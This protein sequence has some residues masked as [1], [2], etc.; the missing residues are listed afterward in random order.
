MSQYRLTL[1]NGTKRYIQ[2]KDYDRFGVDKLATAF[3]GATLHAEDPVSGDEYEWGVEDLKHSDFYGLRPR[4]YD[5]IDADAQKQ[6]TDDVNPTDDEIVDEP[7]S[8]TTGNGKGAAV[9]GEKAADDGAGAVT[10]Q[11]ANDPYGVMNEGM[12]GAESSAMK[13]GT[14]GGGANGETIGNFSGLDKSSGGNATNGETIGNGV[15]K[16]EEGYSAF[17]K[18]DDLRM[19]RYDVLKAPGDVVTLEDGTQKKKADVVKEI[20][21]HLANMEQYGEDYAVVDGKPMSK[22]NA[23]KKV[24][25]M[26]KS[27]SLGQWMAAKNAEIGAMKPENT[28]LSRVYGDKAKNGSFGMSGQ[29]S[30]RP[31][32]QNNSGLSFGEVNRAIKNRERQQEINVE[33][34]K[35]DRV[36]KEAYENVVK[37]MDFSKSENST[38]AMNAVAGRMRP[39]AVIADKEK[40]SEVSPQGYHDK[41][42]ESLKHDPSVAKLAYL[43]GRTVDDTLKDLDDYVMNYTLGKEAEK[44]KPNSVGDYY[45]KNLRNSFIGRIATMATEDLSTR[46]AKQMALGEYEQG[47]NGLAA[48]GSEML[49]MGVDMVT[50][51]PMFGKVGGWIGQKVFSKYAYTRLLQETGLASQAAMRTAMSTATKG[52]MIVSR[53]IGSGTTFATMDATNSLMSGIQLEGKADFGSALL[54]GMRGFGLGSIVGTLGYGT[55]LWSKGAGKLSKMGIGAVGIGAEAGV[56]TLPEYIEQ[57]MNEDSDGQMQGRKEGFLQMFLKNVAMVKFFKVFGEISRF[58]DGVKK[59]TESRSKIR[60]GFD[61]LMAD[62]PEMEFTADEIKA[63]NEQGYEGKDTREVMISIARSAE[64]ELMNMPKKIAE[65]SVMQ[66]IDWMTR[67]TKLGDMYL[68][69]LIPEVAKSKVNYFLTGQPMSAS[70]VIACSQVYKDEDGKYVVDLFT[71]GADANMGQLYHRMKFESEDEAQEYRMNNVGSF[72]AQKI[73]LLEGLIHAKFMADMDANV[74]K[75]AARQ[76]GVD[77][78]SLF[79]LWREGAMGKYREWREVQDGKREAGEGTWTDEQAAQFEYL[80]AVARQMRGGFLNAADLVNAR[81]AVARKN[82]LTSDELKAI[83]EKPFA[84]RDVEK[85]EQ[86]IVAEYIDELTRRMGTESHEAEATERAT[87][88]LKAGAEALPLTSGNGVEEAQQKTEGNLSG[89]DESSG[90][91]AD[92][93]TIGNGGEGNGG[94][95]VMPTVPEGNEYWQQDFQALG[96]DIRAMIDGANGILETGDLDT[97]LRLVDENA[98]PETIEKWIDMLADDKK[99]AAKGLVKGL[100]QMEAQRRGAEKNAKD[101]VAA[102][103]ANM[104]QFLNKQFARKVVTEATIGSGDSKELVYVIGFAG[105]DVFV[106]HADGRTEQLPK[107]K[108]SIVREY[109]LDEEYEQKTAE[110]VGRA[111]RMADFALEHHP[112]TVRPYEGAE[113]KTYDGVMKVVGVDEDGTVAMVHTVYDEKTRT[114]KPKNEQPILMDYEKTLKEQDDY[115]GKVRE[116]EELAK[117][118]AERK[119]AEEKARVEAE[120]KAEEERKAAEEA[121]RKQAEEQAKAEEEARKRAEEEEA[122][123]AAEEEQKRAEEENKQNTDKNGN[124]VDED[125][126]LVVEIAKSVDDIGD[127]D[128]ENPTRNVQLPELSSQVSNAIGTDGKPVVIKKNIFEKN[129]TNHPELNPNESRN[130]LFDALYRTNLYGQSQ[131]I[132]RPDYK[133]AIHTG[134]KNS[135]VVL[136]VYKGKDNV[137]IIGWRKIDGE[138]LEKLKRQAAREGGQFLILSPDEG[139][140]AALSALPSDLSGGKI[141]ENDGNKQEISPKNAEIK[142]TDEQKRS[143]AA[144]RAAQT[145]K[146]RGGESHSKEWREAVDE[147]KHSGY[148][149]LVEMIQD[150]EPKDILDVAAMIISDGDLMWNTEDVDGREIKGVA[151]MTGYKERDRRKFPYLFRTRKSGGI[152]VE[153]A[154]DRVTEMCRQLGIVYD[155]ADAMAGVNAIIEVIRGAQSVGDIKY[156]TEKR[157]VQRARDEFDD[158]EEEREMNGGEPMKPNYREDAGF[159]HNIEQALRFGDKEG[160]K[161]YKKMFEVLL[162]DYDYEQIDDLRNGVEGWKKSLRI[163]N[164]SSEKAQAIEWLIK[165][166]ENRIQRLE[167]KNERINKRKEAALKAQEERKRKKQEGAVGNGQL[168]DDALSSMSIQEL[169]DALRKTSD[170]GEKAKISVELYKARQMQGVEESDISDRF[171]Q[172]IADEA[173]MRKELLLLDSESDELGRKEDEYRELMTE[174][175]DFLSNVDD[176]ELLEAKKLPFVN[177]SRNVFGKAIRKEIERRANEEE[178]DRME[179][180][181]RQAEDDVN[182]NPTEAQKKA[183]NYKMGHISFKGF[184]FTIENTKGSIRSGKDADGNEWS[185]KMNNTYGYIRGTEGVDGDHIDVFLSDNPQ[186]GK[187]YVVD[188]V[189][190]DGSFDEHKVMFGFESEDEAR[191]AYLANYSEGWHGLGKITEV[192]IADFKKWIDS[193]H[194]KTKPFAEYAQSLLAEA[195]ESIAAAEGVGT[196]DAWKVHNEQVA[197][198]GGLLFNEQTK[199]LSQADVAA[200]DMFG[201]SIGRTIEFMTGDAFRERYGVDGKGSFDSKRNAIVINSDICNSEEALYWTMSHESTHAIKTEVS[202][203]VWDGFVDL[204]KQSMGADEFQKKYD[205]V[206]NAYEEAYKASNEAGK[207]YNMPGEADIEEEIC[208]NWAGDIN[209]VGDAERARDLIDKAIENDTDVTGIIQ[210]LIKYINSWLSRVKQLWKAAPDDINAEITA[211]SEAL[212]SARVTWKNMYMIA[213]KNNEARNGELR[214]EPAETKHALILPELKEKDKEIEDKLKRIDEAIQD[215]RRF[216]RELTDAQKESILEMENQRRELMEER[217]NLAWEEKEA[218]RMFGLTDKDFELPKGA[219]V[220]NYKDGKGRNTGFV[221][222]EFDFEGAEAEQKEQV[223]DALPKMAGNFPGREESSGSGTDGET[224]GNGGDETLPLTPGDFYQRDKSSGKKEKTPEDFKLRRLKSGEKCYVERRYVEDKAFTFNG[225]EKIESPEDIAYLFRSLED[226]AIENV[227]FVLIKNGKATILHAG[228]GDMTGSPADQMSPVVAIKNIKPDAIVFVHNHPGGSLN[229][230]GADK[231]IHNKLYAM[232]GDKLR[233]SIIIDQKSGKYSEFEDWG[234]IKEQQRPKDAGGES[235]DYKVY[236]FSK[237]VFS[238]DYVFGENK[239]T[240]SKDIAAFISSH[241]LGD[242]GKLGVLLA[243]GQ[244]Y[245]TANMFLKENDLTQENAAKIADEIVEMASHTSSRTAFI[246]GS[247]KWDNKAASK[248]ANIVKTKSGGAVSV[249]DALRLKGN[250]DDYYSMDDHG[251]LEE[252]A[253]YGNAVKFA[254][255]PELAKEDS[256]NLNQKAKEMFG[257]TNDWRETRWLLSDGT[258]L[259]FSEKKNGGEPGR[260]D[261]DHR[262]IGN[263]YDGKM[264]ERW[265]YLADFGSRG[266]IRLDAGNGYGTMELMRK[267]TKEQRE[268][269]NFFIRKSEGCLDIDFMNDNYDVDHSVSYEDATSSRILADIDR[270]YDD[271]LKPEGNVKFSL[272]EDEYKRVKD[273]SNEFNS[274]L[275]SYIQNRLRRHEYLNMHNYGSLS[276]YIPNANEIII[277]QSVLNKVSK[278]HDIDLRSIRNLPLLL[279]DPILTFRTTRGDS[280]SVV[281]LIEAKDR[282]GNNIVVAIDL[283]GNMDKLEVN[284]V[285]SLYGKDSYLGYKNW[286]DSIISGDVDKLKKWI[287]S[288]PEHDVR[289]VSKSTLEILVSKLNE[290]LSGGKDTEN[291]GTEQ[292]IAQKNAE[293]GVKFAL[294]PD[295]KPKKV[296]TVYKMMRKYPD[297]SYGWLFIDRNSRV[298]KGSWY[299]GD[300]PEIKPFEEKFAEHPNEKHFWLWSEDGSIEDAGTKMP[301]KDEVNKATEEGKRYMSTRPGAKD[302]GMLLYNVG[303]SGNDGTTVAEYAFRP[304]IHATDTPSAGHIGG[305]LQKGVAGTDVNTIRYRAK[306]EVWMECEV[307]DDVDYNDEALANASLIKSGANKGKKNRKEAQLM[308]MPED[309]SYYYRTNTNADAIQDWIIAGAIRPVRELSDA[310]VA[311]LNK[312][313]KKGE[314]GKD[315]QFSPDAVRLSDVEGLY[316]TD[317]ELHQNAKKLMEQERK[318]MKAAGWEETEADASG[319][320]AGKPDGKPSG[321]FADG[322]KVV[323]D[324]VKF[325][326]GDK[327][328]NERLKNKY[329]GVESRKLFVDLQH[330]NDKDYDK[331]TEIARRCLDERTVRLSR[332]GSELDGSFSTYPHIA[333][334]L[335]AEWPKVDVG[336]RGEDREGEGN[337]DQ[338]PRSAETSQSI[339]V[340]DADQNKQILNRRAESRVEV[341]AKENGCWFDYADIARGKRIGGGFECEV[342]ESTEKEGYVVKTEFVNSINEQDNLA[343][344]LDDIATFNNKAEVETVIG[345]TRDNNGIFCIVTEQPY[346]KGRTVYEYFAGDT[347]KSNA[348][349]DKY[350]ESL[351]LEEKVVDDEYIVWTDGKFTYFDTNHDNLIIDDNGDIHIID[352]KIRL[353]DGSDYSNGDPQA[354]EPFG[355]EDKPSVNVK[356]AI[357]EKNDPF[358]SNAAKAVEGIKQ[359]KATPEQWLKMIEK[360]GGL[361]KGED[362]WMGLSEWLEDAQQKT[363]GN[364]PGRDESSGKARTLTK[365]EVMDFI[366]KNAIKIEE[367]NYAEGKG[368]VPISL[369]T[370]WWTALAIENDDY[371]AAW[372]RLLREDPTIDEDYE[373]SYEGDIVRRE[374]AGQIN[375]TRLHYT[376]DGLTNRREIAMTVPNIEAWNEKDEIHFGDAGEGRAV[377]WTRF[378]DAQTKYQG[379]SANSI[380][381]GLA[382]KYGDMKSENMSDED[383]ARKYFGYYLARGKDANRTNTML[384]IVYDLGDQQESA[385]AQKVIDE[386]MK[387]IDEYESAKRDKVL[388]VD[389]VQSKRHQDAREVIGKDADGNPIR[390]GYRPQD[391]KSKYDQASKDI[392]AFRERMREKYGMRFMDVLQSKSMSIEEVE[393]YNALKAEEAKYRK[394]FEWP[395]D[396]PF[397]S[398][399]M[400]LGMKRMLRYAAENGYDKMAWT[401]GEQQARRYDIGGQVK[402][403]DVFK[404]TKDSMTGEP[405]ESDEYDV[406]A[407]DKEGNFI[408]G[409]GGRMN[410]EKMQSI[411]GKELAKKMMDEAD[412]ANGQEVTLSGDDLYVGGEGMKGFYDQ[413]IP[414]FMQKYVKK[415]GAKVEEVE[416]DLPNENDRK[417]WSVDITPEMKESVMGGQ[418]MFALAD[419]GEQP[420]KRRGEDVRAFQERLNRWRADKEEFERRVAAGETPDN[421]V[422]ERYQ[423]ISDSINSLKMQTMIDVMPIKAEGETDDAFNERMNAYNQRKAARDAKLEE[424]KAENMRIQAELAGP[425]EKTD[426]QHLWE[427]TLPPPSRL[428]GERISDEEWKEMQQGMAELGKEIGKSWSKKQMKKDI[429]QEIIERRKYIETS[430]LEDVYFAEDLKDLARKADKDDWKNILRDVPF[431]IEYDRVVEKMRSAELARQIAEGE[432]GLFLLPENVE[433]HYDPFK[434]KPENREVVAEIAEK[435]SDWFR[436]QYTLMQEENVLFGASQLE[437]YVTHIWDFD[438]SPKDAVERYRNYMTA[439]RQR[440]PYTK[441]RVLP[442]LQAGLDMGLVPKY[443]DITGIILDYGHRATETI[444][445]KRLIDFLSDFSLE[446][447]NGKDMPAMMPIIVDDRNRDSNYVRIDNQALEGKKVLRDA[448]PYINSV[449]GRQRILDPTAHPEMQKWIDRLFWTPS[450]LMKKLNLTLSFFHHGA[451]TETAVALSNPAR[452]AKVLGKDM[453][454]EFLVKGAWDFVKK[455]K[456]GTGAR[457]PAM[458]DRAVTRDAVKHLVTLGAT[459]DYCTTDVQNVSAK[460]KEFLHRLPANALGTAYVADMVDFFN[461]GSDKLLWDVIHDGFKI[462]AYKKYAAKIRKQA[463]KEGWDYDKTEKALDELGQFINDTFGGQHWDVLGVS[464]MNERLMRAALLSPDWTVSTIRQ[465]L[466]PLGV[467][468]LYESDSFWQ[469]VKKNGLGKTL[470]DTTPEGLRKKYGRQFWASAAFYFGVLINAWNAWNR[471]K[472]VDEQQRM[473]EEKRMIDPGYKSPY[474]LAYPDGMKWYDYTMFGNTLGQTSHLFY[475]RDDQNREVY[476]RW[477]KQFRELP[478]LFI[479]NQ[480]G[481]VTFPGALINK[482]AGK[483]NPMVNTFVNIVSGHSLSGWENEDMKGL[484]GRE[485]DVARLFVLA[486][487]FLPYSIP[488]DSD[489][490][491]MLID[492]VMPTSKGMSKYKARQYMEKAIKAGDMNYVAEVYKACVQNG[493]DPDAIFETVKRMIESDAKNEM[494]DG[495]EDLDEALKV[496]NE[497]RNASQKEK[498]RQFIEKQMSAQDHERIEMVDLVDRARSYVN[499]DVVPEEKNEEY[500]KRSTSEDVM[501]AWRFKKTK[502]GVKDYYDTYKSLLSD[503]DDFDNPENP[504]AAAYLENNRERIA[505]KMLAERYEYR[506][507]KLKK[508][509]KGDVYGTA[510]MSMIR[511]AY[512]DFFKQ[513]ENPSKAM[514]EETWLEFDFDDPE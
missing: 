154:G 19:M 33:Y 223:D 43:T 22:E 159:D 21:D 323:A 32:G 332:L 96:K 193:S 341:W 465:A 276:K 447:D 178:A 373:L 486:K 97:A 229:P 357:V 379:E 54:A 248:I 103:K 227:F 337:H 188:Q 473:A 295:Y 445:N 132:K 405:I 430:N 245:V 359:E 174:V 315:Y 244:H 417:M 181:M 476:A 138:G 472:D 463:E 294:A 485:K 73:N 466:A 312:R 361:K 199:G 336:Q 88:A 438:R 233:P 169:E 508:M 187:I 497:S 70:P 458:V 172:M 265:K 4:S 328:E 72:E 271:G 507:N 256:D 213:V 344:R 386:T 18:A 130:I 141:T 142:L 69:G 376:T 398:N 263:I 474:E 140:A 399:W 228:M 269:L 61:A 444:A 104:E 273:E 428:T 450:G 78:K 128:F 419:P 290:N 482:M 135:V 247:G 479:D 289:G 495:I 50:S 274:K 356:F 38:D 209:L 20:D 215:T 98:T 313:T 382:A 395:A 316:G 422:A 23:Q 510:V 410:A 14:D 280:N 435:V 49:N 257:V 305:V 210:G 25:A 31:S 231:D 251:V 83:I 35:I 306:D 145:R 1:P 80:Y 329:N 347:D 475:G 63:F 118:E 162:K 17:S 452:T 449:F 421:S 77:P 29:P 309:G 340:S 491:F 9:I 186:R 24:D 442:S 377:V 282:L 5:N 160:E 161:R 53:I 175:G 378:G 92:G 65:G 8:S 503:D 394:M 324:G 190:K 171:K 170:F 68:N 270:Y 75:I 261:K 389:E 401:T 237:N 411:Y 26:Q 165:K 241:R 451:L 338:Q 388:V 434:S 113:I 217:E 173:E 299:K 230:S 74:M 55:Q 184:N 238:K 414:K 102:L 133:V 470:K 134:D 144:Q 152:S 372:R 255:D 460:V 84:E 235:V 440:S 207:K 513:A 287:K 314:N 350:L 352:G 492:L 321:T 501:A 420:R 446:I 214:N 123:K 345:Y 391:Y 488:T 478:E 253:E 375:M 412:A 46:Y 494:V 366:A 107:H 156:F 362:K 288:L 44:F 406:F 197:R 436:D 333:G 318:R 79:A 148:P 326:L 87:E 402:S 12:N 218:R 67:N 158:L 146:A 467:G 385:R 224:I 409:A 121:A 220:G 284:D 471:K 2:S 408:D 112:L 392:F 297:G 275:T 370:K 335:L 351:G 126:K 81:N 191:K 260:R 502:A 292:A 226:S 37:E 432:E 339:A 296:K 201:K 204:V 76:Q 45:I 258:R 368:G 100:L 195:R 456:A 64:G 212:Y 125:G 461:V 108:I 6:K 155:E 124:P 349:I 211:K 86:N 439:L 266:N 167:E 490:E 85:G 254:L 407:T 354:Y 462:D 120:A 477:G 511:S 27:Q 131:P 93:K 343:S 416:L 189:N 240:N 327:K 13:Q 303:L 105:D 427:G 101:Y 355:V 320:V 298:Q 330:Q 114:L 115:Y 264:D 157:L 147:F 400:E 198:R 302:G 129:R 277:R 512:K 311:E 137:E 222:M 307:P 28:M 374:E 259:D 496:Y 166:T 30:F 82:G 348:F 252:E 57:S 36:I 272:S 139:S 208:A 221:Q 429:H 279:H 42:M 16:E 62:A 236:Q 179:A 459:N 117:A 268:K 342:F 293:E 364:F 384:D 325:A 397:G 425:D 454:W 151:A 413:M 301:S 242:R 387:L 34:S 346:I 176:E 457:T 143:N 99:E 300:A 403:I 381:D 39:G 225:K 110:A 304:G 183:G 89:R 424:L 404:I 380:I 310:E 66:Q 232:F 504:E 480:S 250:V 164:R 60:N 505:L 168:S 153:E 322:T 489:K 464:P 177:D 426:D 514:E 40:Q 58:R 47:M 360:A 15:E 483:V 358:Y 500:L 163:I 48:F 150:T 205:L 363:T 393:T 367:V 423:M 509:L 286:A 91:G 185:V 443:N 468:T 122:R 119:E 285:T 149:E 267:P 498:L 234:K 249:R 308:H 453:L 278:K 127:D 418:P 283:E 499:G 487:S 243:N 3:P 433:V 281:A 180:M 41:I 202:K 246:F 396:A 71:M 437:D 200:L 383:A 415:W 390:R 206:K 319:A 51:M 353:G 291:I 493:I 469:K 431:Y 317:S 219:S 10:T 95:Y 455:G 369:R 203:E 94:E 109:D 365:D 7:Q 441:H 196:P 331:A 506:I 90:E 192:S 216:N 262:E 56:F 11:Q 334:R 371:G 448:V 59:G 136:D 182:P 111:V 481:D 194:R 106:K 484:K 52:E 239:I 116:A